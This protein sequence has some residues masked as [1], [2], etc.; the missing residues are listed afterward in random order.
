MDGEKFRNWRLERKE[1]TIKEMGGERAKHSK[2]DPTVSVGGMLPV[3]QLC[4]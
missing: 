4:K 1:G 2:H 3:V